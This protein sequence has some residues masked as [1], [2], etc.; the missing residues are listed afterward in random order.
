MKEAVIVEIRAG[1]G[2]L[3]AKDLVR[4]LSGIYDKYGVRRGL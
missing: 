2:G 1:E 4:K 3:D